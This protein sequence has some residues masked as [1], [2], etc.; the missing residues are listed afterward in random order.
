MI[1]Y[2]IPQD[3]KYFYSYFFL[4]SIG[5]DILKKISCQA[6][7]CVHMKFSFE[8][9]CCLCNLCVIFMPGV[10]DLDKSLKPKSW[11]ERFLQVSFTRREVKNN[12][13]KSNY[14]YKLWFT[15]HMY[16]E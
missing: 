2:S 8:V 6:N 5:P 3:Q 9:K 14:I 12:K 4:L 15:P 11:F 10:Q 1:H 7:K 13:E 16:Y